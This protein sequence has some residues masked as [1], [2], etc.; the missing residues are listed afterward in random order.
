V[1]GEGG[2]GGG[3]GYYGGGGGGGAGGGSG[4]GGGAGSTFVAPGATNV[5]QSTYT[6]DSASVEVSYSIPAPLVTCTSPVD[7]KIGQSIDP[8]RIVCRTS[9]VDG[10]IAVEG[11]SPGALLFIGPERADGPLVL[12]VGTFP[13]MT[14]SGPP[15][16]TEITVKAFNE[17][18]P[19]TTAHVVFKVI[20]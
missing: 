20:P 15:R 16:Q 6:T 19:V 1:L 9:V 3:G 8:V 18:G 7:L 17:G 14:V 4:G 5:T 12:A 11:P 13:G 10:D 2:G